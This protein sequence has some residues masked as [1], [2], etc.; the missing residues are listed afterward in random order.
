MK[1]IIKTLF[2]SFCLFLLFSIIRNNI[3]DKNNNDRYKRDIY[4]LVLNKY[5]SRIVSVLDSNKTYASLTFWVKDTNY[6]ELN[7]FILS[8][9][10]LSISNNDYCKGEE[11]IGFVFDEGIFYLSYFYP[12]DKRKK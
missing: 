9:G 11:Y 1:N 7:S 5:K 12:D 3:E 6:K 4:H 10:F 2:I 8:L